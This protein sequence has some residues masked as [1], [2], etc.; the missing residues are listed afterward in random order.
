M[1][2]GG[3]FCGPARDALKR[4]TTSGETPENKGIFCKNWSRF[5]FF[6]VLLELF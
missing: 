4:L 5:I 6:L 2:E 3:I 1:E